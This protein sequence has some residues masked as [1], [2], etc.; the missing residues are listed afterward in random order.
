LL[1]RSKLLGSVRE[2][3]RQQGLKAGHD[4]ENGERDTGSHG[5]TTDGRNLREAS[6]D[7]E[8][9]VRGRDQLHTLDE[10]GSRTNDYAT[11]KLKRRCDVAI[12]H[13]RES[14]R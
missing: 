9:T 10:G 6:G 13:E 7:I 5:S 8:N 11:W 1:H 4:R 12:P 3:I 2:I 14:E